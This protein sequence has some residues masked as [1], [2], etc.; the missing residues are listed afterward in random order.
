M[1]I[2]FATICKK[3]N[4]RMPKLMPNYRPNWRRPL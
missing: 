3:M 1:Q 4:S 2:E